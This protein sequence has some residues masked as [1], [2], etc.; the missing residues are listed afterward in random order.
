MRLLLTNDDG[1]DA[2]GIRAL[3]DALRLLGYTDLWIVAP[4][5]PYSG[6]GH[7]ISAT[8][9][10]R[11][12]QLDGMGPVTVV[13]GTPGDCVRAAVA[14]RDG[15]TPTW[16]VSGINRGSNL[17]VDL[18]YSGTVAAAREAAIIGYP[19]ISISQLVRSGIPDD[20]PRTSRY[21]AA[22][23]DALLTP[24]DPPSPAVDCAI[25]AATREAIRSAGPHASD[26]GF[27]NVN[28]P[29]L[30]PGQ[31]PTSVAVVPASTDPLVIQ[32]DQI[33]E[34]GGRVT[35]R[36]SGAYHDRHAE[37]GTDVSVVFGGGIALSRLAI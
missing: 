12:E 19:S 16:V 1:Y 35:L 9:R 32:Y 14:L 7:A 22:V 27:W 4:S 36:Y 13:E 8:M 24:D 17:G 26:R 3:W 28:I 18:Y 25:A 5:E 30:P 10:C 33:P 31:D 15:P 23:L 34:A 37:P 11:R 21:A 6:K 2:P 29:S 20:W